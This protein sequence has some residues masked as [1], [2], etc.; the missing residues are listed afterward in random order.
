MEARGTLGGAALAIETGVVGV[1]LPGDG[2]GVHSIL[3]RTVRIA[4]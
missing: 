4:W 2:A 1:T 3:T